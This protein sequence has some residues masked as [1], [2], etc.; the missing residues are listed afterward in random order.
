MVKSNQ[1]DIDQTVRISGTIF[2]QSPYFDCY[3]SSD[4]VFGVYAG[5]FSPWVM[6]DDS[7]EKYWALRRKAAIYDVPEK[8]VLDACS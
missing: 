2:E 5:R 3:A 7:V 1:R 6:G 4:I 8:P